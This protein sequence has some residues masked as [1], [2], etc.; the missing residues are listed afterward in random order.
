VA[1]AMPNRPMNFRLPKWVIDYLEMRAAERNETKT[2]V[3]V[4]AVA[5]LRDHET[6]TLMAEG[7]REMAE[8]SLAL[9]EDALPAATETLPE[10]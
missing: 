7:Y 3:I 5:C 1:T 6:A 4:E 9:A 2:Q 10:W 8:E